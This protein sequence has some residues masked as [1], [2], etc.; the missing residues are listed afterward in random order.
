MCVYYIYVCEIYRHPSHIYFTLKPTVSVLLPFFLLLPLPTLCCTC[1]ESEVNLRCC[2]SVAINLAFETGSL[3][4]TWGSLG[5]LAN[6]L[7]RSPCLCF[8]RTGI[9]VHATGICFD[10]GLN[11]RLSRAWEASAFWLSHLL[12]PILPTPVSF[13]FFVV[14]EQHLQLCQKCRFSGPTP[15]PLTVSRW[16]P[17][18]QE[19][20]VQKSLSSSSFSTVFFPLSSVLTLL[21]SLPSNHYVYGQR[22]NNH[23]NKHSPQGIT[24]KNSH[25]GLCLSFQ[26]LRDETW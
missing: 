17:T 19:S 24:Y 16:D 21:S 10:V 26:H 25:S 6:K 15:D 14:H 4:G 22:S 13:S 23:T 8:P 12:N 1:V 20:L 5:W 2:S 18:L 11:S 3:T 9:Q 7:H